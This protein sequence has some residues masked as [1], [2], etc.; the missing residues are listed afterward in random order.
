MIENKLSDL[1]KLNSSDKKKAEREGLSFLEAS[2]YKKSAEFN[3]LEN[4]QF[5]PKFNQNE[6][7]SLFEK[8]M[9][10]FVAN[11]EENVEL[12]L[13]LSKINK[14]NQKN[15][16]QKFQ[17]KLEFSFQNSLQKNLVQRNSIKKFIALLF[18]DAVNSLHKK[19]V[20]LK[21]RIKINQRLEHDF[22]ERIQTL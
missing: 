4:Q 16:S 6:Y 22:A 9:S 1:F 11:F 17:E 14:K 13:I 5:K 7:L 19:E 3:C 10:D 12:N 2:K 18:T 20:V 15:S 8:S 21:G